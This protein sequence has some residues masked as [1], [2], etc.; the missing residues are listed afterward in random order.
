MKAS[1]I[2]SGSKLLKAISHMFDIIFDYIFVAL[3]A[4]KFIGIIAT[5]SVIFGNFRKVFVW[6]SDKF[7]RIFGKW[8]KIFEKTSPWEIYL[9]KRKLHGR[10]E[11]RS[12]SSRVFSC[13]QHSKINFV[14]SLGHVVPSFIAQMFRGSYVRN[15]IKREYFKFIVCYLGQSWFLYGWLSSPWCFCMSVNCYCPS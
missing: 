3:T 14:S 13:F 8:S 15:N 11:I 2:P 6:P 10:L 7:W 5:S 9:M 1:V 4:F 12:F